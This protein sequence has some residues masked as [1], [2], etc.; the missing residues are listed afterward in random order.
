[1][2]KEEFIFFE[3]LEARFFRLPNENYDLNGWA[4]AALLFLT[5]FKFVSNSMRRIRILEAVC[6]TQGTHCPNRIKL[7]TADIIFYLIF[8]NYLIF[9]SEGMRERT[10]ENN[11]RL[12]ISCFQCKKSV[13]NFSSRRHR[14]LHQISR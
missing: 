13:D 14:C 7:R 8:S 12:T 6:L 3:V 4:A 1:M 11:V 5:I 2:G 10:N 9:L